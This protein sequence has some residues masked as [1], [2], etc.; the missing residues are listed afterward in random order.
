MKAVFYLAILAQCLALL[1][2]IGGIIFF[3]FNAAP[4]AFM[5]SVQAATGGT[6]ISG[7]IVRGMLD[8]FTVWETVCAAIILLAL[9]E[10]MRQ[11]PG[12]RKRLIVPLCITLLMTALLV[13]YGYLVGPHMQTLAATIGDFNVAD[14]A[15]EVY[16][17]FDVLHHRYER[18]LSANLFLGLA[19]FVI[20]IS[21]IPSA[22]RDR[23]RSMFRGIEI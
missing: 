7:R 1:V 19:L 18:L 12:R 4:M 16:Q 17:Q 15:S 21:L 23:D 10:Q 9:I 11:I 6:E 14:K 20:T 22:F 2:W 8:R 3:A 13:W 5:D